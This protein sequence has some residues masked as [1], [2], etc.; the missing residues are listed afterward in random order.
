MAEVR[1]ADR[2]SKSFT[3]HALYENSVIYLPTGWKP[4]GNR[5]KSIL[6]HELVHHVQRTNNV[7]VPCRG[8]LEQEAYELQ[9]RWLEEHGEADP[10]K[11]IGTTPFTVYMLYACPDENDRM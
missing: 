11:L 2:A 9:V 10:Y 7:T 4:A 3:L 5:E 1:G 8:A 6:L